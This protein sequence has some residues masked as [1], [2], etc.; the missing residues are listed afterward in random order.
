MSA[1]V[2]RYGFMPYLFL[3]SRGIPSSYISVQHIHCPPTF[4]C[5]KHE[6]EC[7]MQNVMKTFFASASELQSSDLYM[8][9]KST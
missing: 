3:I 8:T 6:G 4:G 5:V 2:F 9:I 1:D 7:E